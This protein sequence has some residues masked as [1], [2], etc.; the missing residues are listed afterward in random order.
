M[1][2]SSLEEHTLPLAQHHTVGV[3]S[4]RLSVPELIFWVLERLRIKHHIS[5][6]IRSFSISGELMYLLDTDSGGGSVHNAGRYCA[7]EHSTSV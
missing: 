3:V 6:V 5:L 4:T 7:W 1:R 2:E